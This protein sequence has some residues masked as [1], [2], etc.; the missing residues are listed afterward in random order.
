[1]PATRAKK[2]PMLPAM[3]TFSRR[4]LV[5]SWDGVTV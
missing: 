1:M 4:G 2:V 3:E 5:A